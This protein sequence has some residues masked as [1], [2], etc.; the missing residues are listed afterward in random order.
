MNQVLEAIKERRSIR[1]YEPTPVPDEVLQQVLEAIQWSPSW[2]NSQCWEVVVIK[3]QGIKEKLQGTMS[4]GNPS[5]KAIVDAPVL[6]AMCAKMERSGFY[7]DEASTILGDWFMYDLGLATQNVLLT[8]HSLG[9][10]A[11]VVGLYDL[12]AAADVL[13][14]PEDCQLVSLIPLGYPAKGSPA[15]KRREIAEFTRADTF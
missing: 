10:G 12:E 4:K 3:D 1:K 7:K 15:P 5:T 14:V 2:A 8:A 6:L 11:V 9:L 13:N